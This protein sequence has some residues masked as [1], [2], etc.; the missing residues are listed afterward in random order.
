MSPP[1]SRHVS[2]HR[3]TN[4]SS[5]SGS[6][7]ISYHTLAA[8]LVD[9]NHVQLSWIA[10][11]AIISIISVVNMARALQPEVVESHRLEIVQWAIGV[12]LGASSAMILVERFGLLRP[13]V[14]LRVGLVYQV[15]I[16]GALSVF[17]NS[18]QWRSD[19]FVRGTSS[20]TVW[21]IAFALLVPAAPVT[22]AIF[23]LASAAMGPIGHFA[24]T[25]ALGLPVAPANRLIIYYSPCFLLSLVSA[26][27]NLRILRLE[28]FAATAR[29][30]GAYDLLELLSRGGMGEIWRA[31][32]RHLKR[33][34]ALK[35]IRPDFLVTQS[36][37]GADTLRKRFE[38]EARAIAAL[39]SPHTVAIHDFGSTEDGGFYYAME[40]LEG[41]DLDQLVKRFGPLPVSRVV[42]IIVQACDSLEEAHRRSMIHRDI[43]PSNL[44]L[45]NLGTTYDFC[46]LLDFGLVKRCLPE[47]EGLL[48]ATGAT[49]GT[50]AFMAPE[51]ASGSSFDSRSDIYGLGCV[52]YW[53]VTGHLLFEEPT[54]MATILAHLQ[55]EPVAPSKRTEMQIPPAFDEIILSCLA[56]NPADRP[57]SA[58]ALGRSLAGC[59]DIPAWRQ[60]DAGSWWRSNAPEFAF[61]HMQTPGGH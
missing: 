32:H 22:A 30:K 3:A 34:A 50:P 36:G 48:T 23:N 49:T 60:E 28:W 7:R 51:V 26:L 52:A 54:P 46:K 58:F 14:L 8:E 38:R 10:G 33:D 53:L 37:R 1:P 47:D 2:V 61:S 43:K 5:D 31:R 55:K 25:M 19:E 41:F 42:W 11:A 4:A 16:A 44:F 15:V 39:K 24:V 6:H 35:I 45:C 21:L 57:S 12:S 20:I 29:E 18:I 40:L 13:I 56:K 27:I 17:E 59:P 9:K